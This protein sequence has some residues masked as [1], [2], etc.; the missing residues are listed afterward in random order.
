MKRRNEDSDLDFEIKFYEELIAE[1]CDF[2]EVLI[3]LAEAY[4]K[5]G[6]YRKGLELDI[7]LSK[8]KPDDPIV[9]YNL[10]CSYSLTNKLEE[11]LRSLERALLLGYRDLNFMDKDKDLVNLKRDPRYTQLKKKYQR[12]I[13]AGWDG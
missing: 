1:K 4:T 3:S 6:L 11:S 10:S 8:L 13:K 12:E 7:R 2:V 5:K 9:F